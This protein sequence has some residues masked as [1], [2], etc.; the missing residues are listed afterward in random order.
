[1]EYE[2]APFPPLLLLDATVVATGVRR[3]LLLE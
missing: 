2:A 1:V 3:N